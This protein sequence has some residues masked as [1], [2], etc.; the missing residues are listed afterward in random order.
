MTRHRQTEFLRALQNPALYDHPV[1]GFEVIETHISW[2]LLTGPCAYKIKKPVN[3]GFLD[4]SSLEKRH[5]FCRE[6]LRLNRRL[7]P[8]LYLD[9]VSFTG[10][11]SRPAINGEGTPFEYGVKMRQ[12]P[13]D[14]R[15]DRVLSRGELL[16]AHIDQLARE[17]ADFH[18]RI[19]TAD[20]DSPYGDPEA[21]HKHAVDNFITLRQR[22]A[23][24]ET[25][26]SI[27]KVAQWSEE[28]FG[29]LRRS[30]LERKRGGY[31]RE[32]HGD[33]HLGNMVLLDGKVTVFDC[34]EFNPSLSWIDVM[35]ELAFLVM[36]LEQRG[37]TDFA[38]RFLNGELERSG[39]YGGVKLLTYYLVYRA[40]VRAKVA[41]IQLSQNRSHRQKEE[42]AKRELSEYLQL[43]KGYTRRAEPHLFITHGFSGAGKTHLTQLLLE[44]RRAIRIRSDVE[45]KRLFG[46]TPE[47]RSNSALREGIYTPEAT[48]RLYDHLARLAEELLESGYSVIVDAT[49]LERAQRAR[50][51]ALA[52]RLGTGFTLL[53]FQASPDTLR[54]RIRKRSRE[55]K[56]ASEATLAVLERQLAAH[57]PLTPDE[58][59]HAVIIDTERE[60]PLPPELLRPE[61]VKGPAAPG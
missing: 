23:D 4:F 1:T 19:A 25:E 12:F 58:R 29:S 41:G 9:V 54:A 59:S 2:V 14:A 45:R 7:A 53:D 37:R 46:L 36:D 26:R 61:T 30:M 49:F 27:Q 52:R 6:E 57:E 21:I 60:S 13:A 16:P 35:N 3:L 24:D 43:A 44:R 56:D 5:H 22:V 47:S 39:D 32:C 10:S 55:G 17:I 34:I 42:A 28:R 50:F 11:P 20:T 8:T 38:F 18:A 33:M 15:L 48:R 31:I 40:M 51:Q